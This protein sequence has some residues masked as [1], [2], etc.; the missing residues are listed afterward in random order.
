MPVSFLFTALSTLLY[1]AAVYTSRKGSPGL[2]ITGAN[3][4]EGG[5]VKAAPR[6]EPKTP[7]SLDA[8]V[9]HPLTSHSSIVRKRPQVTA[10]EK[11]ESGPKSQQL[12][13][14]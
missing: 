9:L 8:A 11:Y 5:G 3:K 7:R 13:A 12:N 2:A 6:G 1:H 4:K 14:Q 10:D